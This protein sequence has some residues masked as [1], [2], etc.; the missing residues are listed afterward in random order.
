MVKTRRFAILLFFFTAASYITGSLAVGPI[1]G[2]FIS[3]LCL[4]Y[5][6]W[7]S[8]SLNIKDIAIRLAVY[9]ASVLMV[10]RGDALL[11]LSSLILICLCA[12]LLEDVRQRRSELLMYA[13]AAVL[14]YVGFFFALF[15]EPGLKA[16]DVLS[17]ALSAAGGGLIGRVIHVGPSYTGCGQLLIVMCYLTALAVFRWKER[18]I[19]LRVLLALLMVASLSIAYVSVWSLLSETQFYGVISRLEPL[20]QPFDYR[21]LQFALLLAPVGFASWPQCVGYEA[22][23]SEKPSSVPVYAAAACAALLLLAA[24]ALHGTYTDFPVAQKQ[25]AVIA[26]YSTQDSPVML[27]KPSADSYGLE[28]AGMFGMLPEYLEA[29]GYK[30]IIIDHINSESLKGCDALMIVNLLKKLPRESEE[31][32]WSFVSQG[33]SLLLLGDHTG[34]EQIREPSN[35]LLAP[36]NI[37]FNF[38]SAIPFRDLWNQ[39]FDT[40]WHPVYSG[41]AGSEYQINIG[42]SLSVAYPARSVVL[43]RNGFSDAGDTGNMQNGFLGDMQ[44]ARGERLGDL[45]LVAEAPYGAG[46][47]WVSG[48]TSFVQTLNLS[49]S[50]RYV[51]RLFRWLSS[52]ARPQQVWM[53]IVVAALLLASACAILL[54]ANNRTALMMLA[55]AAIASALVV[56]FLPGPVGD[57]P[58]AGSKIAVDRAAGNFL[59]INRDKN[60]VDGLM[61]NIERNGYDPYLINDDRM[62]FGG[63][64]RAIVEI[65]PSTPMSASKINNLK[66]YMEGGGIVVLA[67]GWREAGAC[68]P[69]LKK[70][71]LTIG[72]MPLGRGEDDR[73]G[74]AANPWEA[75]PVEM[76]AATKS[77][78][79]ILAEE[80]DYPVAVWRPVGQGG[81]VLICDAQF[82]SNK[83]LEDKYA[84]SKVNIDFIGSMVSRFINRK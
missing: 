77:S 69:F 56:N 47:I 76:D 32:V 34:G 38:D 25:G 64:Y 59:Q 73:A 54:C 22:D 6:L 11:S 84:F 46:K 60:S 49:Y 15:T 62:L 71:G 79:Q 5:L 65:A 55:G 53:D 72:D 81:L 75:W 35:E 1:S 33:H 48:D 44:F 45:T 39:S 27:N 8:G 17:E 3:M 74:K 52:S 24:S 21:L 20:V 70:F 51:S 67:A 83:N 4:A 2:K 26:L 42:A 80:W 29:D 14:M 19:R 12:A 36:V 63:G 40:P 13:L 78:V 30:V 61:A 31:S 16:F 41:L 10:S 28:N 18:R 66:D 68:G 7:P 23:R 58:Y 50:H 37:S 57:D 9:A 82:F 43:G